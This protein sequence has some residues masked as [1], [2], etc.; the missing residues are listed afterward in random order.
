MGDEPHPPREIRGLRPGT[1]LALSK[2]NAMTHGLKDALVEHTAAVRRIEARTEEKLDAARSWGRIVALAVRRFFDV[3]GVFLSA[4]LAFYTLLYCF[5]LLLLFV[6]AMGYVLEGSERTFAAVQFVLG[7]LLPVSDEAV[8][9][10]LL[11][12]ATHRGVLTLVAASSFLLVGTFLFGAVRHVLNVVFA[13][14]KRRSYFRGLRVDMVVMLA[15]GLLLATAVLATA[16]LAVA[17]DLGA[18]LPELAPFVPRGWTLALWVVGNLLSFWLLYLLY[19]LAPARTLSTG[20][21]VVASLSGVSFLSISRLIFTWYVRA[22]QG[23][24]VFFGALGG[25]LFFVL[26]IYYGSMAFVL[27]AAVGRAYDEEHERAARTS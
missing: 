25:I 22:A 18:T 14:G 16:L 2:A 5:P 11:E 1:V 7:E 3:N 19:R 10:A 27:A 17:R 8:G 12:L 23:Y 13:A 15:V 6:A 26:W 20:G 21:L 4:G 9:H 24:A